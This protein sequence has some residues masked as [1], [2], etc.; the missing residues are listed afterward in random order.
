MAQEKK[1][2]MRRS[3]IHLPTRSHWYGLLDT[4]KCM[5]IKW[6][7]SFE[8][9]EL[10]AINRKNSRIEINY[11]TEHGILKKCKLRESKN[12]D[13]IHILRRCFVLAVKK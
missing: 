13:S 4:R 10:L 9:K 5:A 6:W 1:T 2:G 7:T 3:F 12:K 11:L 8:T